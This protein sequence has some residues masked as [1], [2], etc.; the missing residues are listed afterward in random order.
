MSSSPPRS[1][2]SPTS[3]PADSTVYGLTIATELADRGL[4]VAVVARDLPEDLTSVGFASPWAVSVD[5]RKPQPAGGA[6]RPGLGVTL[7]PVGLG[8]ALE[9]ALTGRWAE[10]RGVLERQQP[11]CLCAPWIW[12]FCRRTGPERLC[13]IVWATYIVARPVYCAQSPCVGLASSS[14]LRSGQWPW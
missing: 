7:G 11:C 10:A 4:K 3:D 13:F 12:D 5:C 6:L 14:C 8:S 9:L 1:A 2:Y